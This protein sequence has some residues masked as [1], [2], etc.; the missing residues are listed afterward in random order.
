M[1]NS[2]EPA[3]RSPRSTLTLS[4]FERGGER[5][6]KMAR[7]GFGCSRQSAGLQSAGDTHLAQQSGRRHLIADQVDARSA[8]D[9]RPIAPTGAREVHRTGAP[10]G[11]RVPPILQPVPPARQTSIGQVLQPGD[12][13]GPSFA[14]E[15]RQLQLP[16]RGR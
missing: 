12:R 8:V 1:L 3:C 7:R 11:H 13:V 14:V 9:R 16:R 2:Y 15:Q 6:G 4:L 10:T 5:S